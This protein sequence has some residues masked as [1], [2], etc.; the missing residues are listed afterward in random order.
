MKHCLAILFLITN[1]AIS[2]GQSSRP[3]GVEQLVVAGET[4]KPG[5]FN[6]IVR[7]T[8]STGTCTGSLIHPDI[9][10]TAAHCQGVWM[11]GVYIGNTRAD[12]RDGLYAP[13]VGQYRHLGYDFD[14]DLVGFDDVMIL[15]LPQPITDIVP[16]QLN[17]NRNRPSGDDRALTAVGFGLTSDGG[18]LPRL[19]QYADLE[20]VPSEVCRFWHEFTDVVNFQEGILW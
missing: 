9:V 1:I 18:F 15:K 8:G 16:I 5:Q 4:A 7:S 3:K 12:G 19:L 11:G 17:S 10:L 2:T 14:R 20:Y 6:W 13:V